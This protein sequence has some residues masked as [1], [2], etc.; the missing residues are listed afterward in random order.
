MVDVDMSGWSGVDGVDLVLC[1]T[2]NSNLKLIFCCQFTCP[3]C[4]LNFV[5]LRIFVYFVGIFL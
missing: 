2:L 3:L 5:L 1:Q 4:G